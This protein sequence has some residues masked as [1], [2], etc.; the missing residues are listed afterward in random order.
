M[1]LS[2]M[3]KNADVKS[4]YS[5][6]EISFVTDRPE[7][8]VKNSAFVCIEGFSFDGHGSID[9][10]EKNGAVVFITQK[11]TG[12]KNQII[13]E[14]TRKTYALMCSRFFSEPSK[15]MKLIG[16]TGTNGKTT[17]AHTIYG[18]LT[19]SGRKAGLI[20][21]AENI[22]DGNRE[23]SDFTTPGAFE[24]NRALRKM[25]DCGTE[26][27]VCEVS[28]Q[29]LDQYRTYPCEFEVG[30]FTNISNEHLDYHHTFENYLS[31]KKKL[32]SQCKSAVINLDDSAAEEII[33]SCGCEIMTF[34]TR[35][36][37]SD[38]TAKDIR[39]YDGYT[40]YAAVMFSE[41]CRVKVRGIGEYSVR[42]SLAAIAV[43]LKL[44]FKLSEAAEKAALISPVAGRGEKLKTNTD[45]SVIV[46]YAHNPDALYNI[47]SALSN[48][49]KGKIITLFGCGGERDREKRADMGNIAGAF[50]DIAVI[51]NDNPRNENE[52]EIINDI[53]SGMKESKCRIYVEKDRAQAI[54]LALM[55]AEKN[56]IVLLAGKGSEAYQT[57]KNEKIPF[58]DRE[59][60]EEILS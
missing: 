58:S 43:M 1:K 52:D 49:K 27:C 51:T 42:N 19:L 4:G 53:L 10:A 11:D 12:R 24:F 47:L 50:S 17:T 44:G 46:D 41:I 28:S 9:E 31:A 40:E 22:I 7:K 30:V 45:Y 57:V 34:S 20:G 15:S 55:N 60:A 36:D 5:D 29:A 21:T 13:V 3:L 14:N 33:S 16:I 25:A 35:D 26:Y 59:K 37:R 39:Y 48:L 23:E 6:V 38:I 2:Q 18:L 54:R 8:C 56:D 32:F